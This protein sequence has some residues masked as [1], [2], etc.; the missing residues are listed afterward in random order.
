M[1]RNNNE[2]MLLKKSEIDF[3]IQKNFRQ[4]FIG[5]LKRYQ[6]LDYV[7][8]GDLEIGSSLY[9]YPKAD[10]PHFHKI[11]SEILYVLNGA[12]KI[13]LIDTKVEYIL[14]KGDFFVLP[15]RTPYIGKSTEKMTQ[16]LFVK[17]GG[18]D[19][20]EIQENESMLKWMKEF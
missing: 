11:S 18:D 2:V 13:L 16:I 14:N 6:E 12:Y 17:I 10:K 4:Y 3:A 5:N 15:A 19:K 1:K 7:D 9:Q 8:L 20:V